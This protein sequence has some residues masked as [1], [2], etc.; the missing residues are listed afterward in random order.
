MKGRGVIV[1]KNNTVELLDKLDELKITKSWTGASKIEDNRVLYIKEVVVRKTNQWTPF[2]KK[3]MVY[4]ELGRTMDV[5]IN[6]DPDVIDYVEILDKELE[7]IFLKKIYYLL[8][9]NLS[10]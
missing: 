4:L 7:T 3:W 8:I 1:R 6:E 9:K 5:D 2:L 10:N